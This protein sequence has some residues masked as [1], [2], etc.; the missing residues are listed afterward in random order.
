MLVSGPVFVIEASSFKG[1][2]F[3]KKKK[4]VKNLMSLIGVGSTAAPRL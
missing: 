4:N 1:S 2:T 3:K